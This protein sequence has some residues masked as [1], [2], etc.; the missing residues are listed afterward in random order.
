MLKVL[1]RFIEFGV[2][3]VKLRFKPALCG[4]LG[5]RGCDELAEEFLGFKVL[6]FQSSGTC[7]AF[8]IKV[9]KFMFALLHLLDSHLCI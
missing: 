8:L 6:S 5:G 9:Q 2:V 1:D 7:I 4:L 3:A